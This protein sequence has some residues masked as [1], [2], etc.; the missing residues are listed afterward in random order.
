MASIGKAR[1][2]SAAHGARYEAYA[3]KK[4]GAKEVFRQN[5]YGTSRRETLIF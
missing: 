1:S 5:I 2:V 3:E 4:E